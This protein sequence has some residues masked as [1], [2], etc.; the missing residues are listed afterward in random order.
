MALCPTAVFQTT[1][2]PRTDAETR[3]RFI[4]ISVDESLEQTR[5]ILEAQRQSCTPAK[6]GAA[7]AV[8]Y[9]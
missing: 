2:D 8:R 6:V 4:I 3:S 5:A 9:S 7:G 1:T